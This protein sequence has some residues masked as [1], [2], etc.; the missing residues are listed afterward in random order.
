MKTGL[1]KAE[2]SVKYETNSGA[3][4]TEVFNTLEELAR[5]AHTLTHTNELTLFDMIPLIVD[6]QSFDD[7]KRQLRA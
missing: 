3:V 7:I 6:Q 5:R 2:F 4:V 1:V